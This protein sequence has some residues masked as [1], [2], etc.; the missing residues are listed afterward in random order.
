MSGPP[1]YSFR[2][3]VTGEASIMSFRTNKTG[4]FNPFITIASGTLRW[5]IDG[6]EQITNSPSKMLTGSTVD[7]QVFA[8]TVP[9]NEIVTFIS[10]SAKNIIG[11]LDYSYF[12]LNTS[13][14]QVNSNANLTDLIIGNQVNTTSTL[15]INNSGW[16]N[17]D[18]TDLKITSVLLGQDCIFLESILFNS[19][20]QTISTFRLQDGNLLS[21]DLSNIR[22][23]RDANISGNTNLVTLTQGSYTA[24]LRTYNASNCALNLSSVDSLFADLNSFFSVTA[25][26]DS[27]TV[28]VSG[29]TNAS[30]TGGSSNTDLV[31]LRDV[32]YPAA[33]RTFTAIIN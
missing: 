16:V 27:L 25:P 26:G 29:G 30:P 3:K 2:K 23:S 28:D 8:N 20:L 14:I 6:E 4:T 32:V 13:Q 5:I 11:L 19:A 1:V 24:F 10:F 17:L 15:L 18:L 33:G 9:A 12:T 22:L 31:N 7:V 21:L